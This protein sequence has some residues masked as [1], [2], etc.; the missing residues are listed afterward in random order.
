MSTAINITVEKTTQEFSVQHNS[1]VQNFSVII[2]QQGLPGVGVPPGGLTGQALLKESDE[3]YKTYWGNISGGGGGSANTI[4]SGTEDP[5]IAQ[6]AVGDYYINDTSLQIFG[7]KTSEGWGVG[8]NL[9][10]PKGD[11]GDQGNTGLS[12]YQVWLLLG[13]Q[14]TEQDFLLTLKGDTGD[15]GEQGASAY[16]AW[17]ALGNVGTPQDFINSLQGPQGDEG[18]SAYEVWLNLGNQGTEQDFI[19]SLVGAKG[20]Q[21]DQGNTG[22]SA[23]QVWLTLGN[24]GT[25]QQFIDSLQGP[26]GDAGVTPV[27]TSGNGTTLQLN[28]I[29]GYYN[30]MDQPSNAVN[31]DLNG[32]VL[33]GWAVTRINAPSIPETTPASVLLGDGSNFLVNT[34]MYMYV[35]WNGFRYERIIADY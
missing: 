34:D 18:F 1:V 24:E 7:P 32:A 11:Q 33:G 35:R 3:D 9:V 28:N 22:L 21:G 12:A 5:V 14:G 31:Y 13:N 26:Q 15:Q 25:E 27:A 16:D 8:R 17:L 19:L 2:A 29:A 20:D 30:N 10:G 4:L 23:F 6:G